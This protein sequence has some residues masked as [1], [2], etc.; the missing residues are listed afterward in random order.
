M[1]VKINQKES[2]ENQFINHPIGYN[3]VCKSLPI[4]YIAYTAAVIK[5]KCMQSPN[6]IKAHKHLGL[7]NGLLL[8]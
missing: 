8:K 1:D 3:F 7:F 4:P 2:P 6:E 5:E